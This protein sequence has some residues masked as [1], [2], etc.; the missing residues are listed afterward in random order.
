[1][2][3][4]DTSA[5]FS[6]LWLLLFILGQAYSLKA[7]E[8]QPM[9]WE[10]IKCTKSKSSKP[11]KSKKPF[12]CPIENCI[13]GYSRNADLV[14]H[15]YEKHFDLFNG[16]TIKIEKNI[17]KYRGLQIAIESGFTKY[18]CHLCKFRFRRKKTF[19]RHSK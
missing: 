19:E 10:F 1:M 13:R 2:K 14:A 3:K 4:S 15:L 18:E 6:T 9:N 16:Q 7:A 11:P 5:I 17:I 8:Q 12:G